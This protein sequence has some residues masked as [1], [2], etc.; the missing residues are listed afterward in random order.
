VFTSA[1][2]RRAVGAIIASTVLGGLLATSLALPA[3]AAETHSLTVS[4]RSVAGTPLT[5]IAVFAVSVANGK[6]IDGDRLPD[7]TYQKATAVTGKPGIYTFASLGDFDHTLYFATPTATTFAQLLGG[8]SDVGRAEVVPSSQATLSVSLATNAVITGTVKSASAKAMNK[9]YVTAYRYTGSEWQMYSTARSDSKGKYTL[10]D[11]DPGSYRLKFEAD[12]S[13]YSPMYSG[14]GASFDAAATYVVGVGSTT[15]VNGT[16]P[17]GTGA[18]SGT[19]R[20]VYEGYEYYGGYG[21][22]KAHAIAIPVSLGAAYPYPRTIDIDSGVAS[23]ATGKSGKWTIKNL[24]PGTYVVKIYPWYYNQSNTYVGTD[25]LTYAKIITVVAGKTSTGNTSFSGQTPQ[26]GSLAVTVRAQ[27][28]GSPIPNAD[29]LLQSDA[30]PDYY[31]RGVTD[32]AGLLTIGQSGTART[33]Q[34]GQFTVLVTT[35]G[36][37]RPV[38]QSVTI[39]ARQNIVQLYLSAPSQ[40][41][42][43]VTAPTIAETSLDVGTEYLVSAQPKRTTATLHYQWSRDGRPIFGADESRYVARAGDIGAQLSVEVT[44]SESGYPDDRATATVAGLV[45]SDESIPTVVTPPSVTPATGAHVG[46]TLRVLPGHWS[47]PGLAFDVQWFRNGVPFENDGDSYVVTLADLDSEFTASVTAHKA[48]HPDASAATSTGVTPVFAESTELVSGLSVTASTSGVPKGSTKYTVSPGAWTALTPSFTYQWLRGGELV[49]EGV[50]FVEKP[51][52]AQRTQAL[53][54]H[55][56][57][58]AEGF[59]DG[60][61]TLQARK[62]AAQLVVSELPLVAVD[63]DLMDVGSGTPVEFG[64]SIAVTQ[65]TWAHGDDPAGELSFTYKWTRKVGKA[66]A[67]TIAGATSAVYVP[68]ATDVGAVLTVVVTAHSTRWADASATLAAGTVVAGS[69]LEAIAP[70]VT[71]GGSRVARSVLYAQFDDQWHSAGAKISYQWYGCLLP[72][73]TAETLTTGF[74][75]IAYATKYSYVPGSSYTNGRVY[76]IVTA[77]KQGSR[78]A[79]AI[80]DVV[81]IAPENTIVT[82]SNPV[83]SPDGGVAVIGASIHAT[84]AVWGSTVWSTAHTWQVCKTDCSSESAVWSTATGYGNTSSTFYPDGDNWAT[85]ESYLRVKNDGTNGATWTSSAYSNAVPL[86]KGDLGSQVGTF[87]IV[88][89]NAGVYYVSRS[90]QFPSFAT[91]SQRWFVNET[92]KTSDLM[93]TPTVDDA[94]KYLY[95]VVT[96]SAP[97]Y[98]DVERLVI[99]AGVHTNN[100]VASPVTINGAKLGDTLTLSDPEPFHDLPQYEYARWKYTYQWANGYGSAATGSTYVP[101]ASH[102]GM[103]V[104]VTITASSPIYGSYS[105]NALMSSALLAGDPLELTA[106][107]ELHWSGDLLPSTTVSVTGQEY[108]DSG[109]TSSYVWQTSSDGTTW[110]TKVGQTASSFTPALTDA[111]LLLRVTVTGIKA[112]HTSVAFTS[113]PVQILE[114]D[115]VRL[116]GAPRLTGD[117]RVGG[118]LTTTMGVWSK[119]TNVTVEWLLNGRTIPGATGSTYVPLPTNAGDEISVRVTGRQPGKLDVVAETAAFAIAK[120]SAPVIVSAPVVTGTTTLTA[121]PG[122][123]SVSG[124]IFVFEWRRDGDIVGTTDTLVMAPDTTRADYVLTV[125]A[126]RYGYEA[127]EYTQP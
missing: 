22:A 51:T 49:G 57:A 108:S 8:A 93:F 24:L 73:C 26:G 124:L 40:Q 94:G 53:D 80:S 99:A 60:S 105:K 110:A 6:E 19:A 79:H 67:A 23:A 38:T 109:V 11:V 70:T 58:A 43:F 101:T 50:T 90:S 55:V 113:A 119:N 44:S 97:G 34:P 91:T 98:D 121:T 77:T 126:T 123:W 96:T 54:V 95:A 28:N 122:V 104:N 111:A 112:G 61:A 66:K 62:A 103:K 39:D 21:M 76:L 106:D 48:G 20:V 56:S 35:K 114:G 78:T 116:V 27:V 85:G 107:P 5:G 37:Y 14:G 12:G 33:I 75:K 15:T 118:T 29:V 71:L 92:E 127:G 25:N 68:K 83:L 36:A 52:S 4:V 117:A 74:T 63:E 102:V 47:V 86:A 7:G 41:A 3:E 84:D 100:F 10:T 81:T 120:A 1:T 32:A 89:N 125:R 46:T 31:Y 2:I 88:H 13:T 45:V 87:T 18:I 69:Q 64:Q 30:D 82:I 59:G 115:V 16:F 65:G 72:K 17:K 9:A 42:G